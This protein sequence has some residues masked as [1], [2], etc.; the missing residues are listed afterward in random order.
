M[1]RLDHLLHVLAMT[2]F[3]LRRLCIVVP[4]AHHVLR[5]SLHSLRWVRRRGESGSLSV[6]D[7]QDEGGPEEKK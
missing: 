5:S 7:V 2:P 1:I 3:L 6:L 4:I